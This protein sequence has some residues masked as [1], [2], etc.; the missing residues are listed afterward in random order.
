M[1]ERKLTLR[2]RIIGV[3]LR[4]ARRR[5]GRTKTECADALGV[6]PSTIDAYEEGHTAISLPELEA[7]GYVLGTPVDRFWE[8]EPK[9]ET[10]EDSP[11]LRAM[12]KLRHRII[13]T[14]LRQARLEA[15]MT[16]EELAEILECTP[17]HISDY[18]HAE[19]PIPVVELE[20][21]GRHL[22]LPL[23]HFLDGQRGTVGAWHRQQAIDRRFH[24]L[25]EDLQAFVSKPAN[26]KY[27]EVARRLS[28]MPASKL[29]GIAE[30]LL[31]ITAEA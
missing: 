24:E 11:D 30:G 29:R 26:I 6:S 25:P 27:L 5:A 21:L 15:D 28:D 10:E 17:G 3:L 22:G 1:V 18:E 9:L 31:E 14:L 13:G 16:Q 23:E 12:L 4:D 7:L 20:L 2:N 8:V 19:R